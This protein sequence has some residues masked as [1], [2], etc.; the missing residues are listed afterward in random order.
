MVKEIYKRKKGIFFF[1]L[2]EQPAVPLSVSWM[3][4]HPDVLRYLLRETC[5]TRRASSDSFGLY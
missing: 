5:Y 4:P 2:L 1:F 3:S